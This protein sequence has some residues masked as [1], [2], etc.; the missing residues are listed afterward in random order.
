MQTG[1]EG[2][3]EGCCK[4]RLASQFSAAHSPFFPVGVPM[5]LVNG[6][7]ELPVTKAHSQQWYYHWSPW[8]VGT[9]VSTHSY[10]GIIHIAALVTQACQAACG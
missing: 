8:A 5:N 2:G 3:N 9:F 10:Y 4:S 1:W 6:P 7:P